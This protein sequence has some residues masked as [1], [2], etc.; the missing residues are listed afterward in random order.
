MAG[1]IP[2]LRKLWNALLNDEV[3]VRRYLRATLMALATGGVGFADQIAA[4]IGPA[5]PPAE[6]GALVMKIKIIAL[7][8]GF[9][10]VMIN[11]GDKNP[12]KTEEPKP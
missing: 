1:M 5:W 4:Q 11:L 10:S 12:Q 3:A 8:S 9:I 6:L 2:L 7:V